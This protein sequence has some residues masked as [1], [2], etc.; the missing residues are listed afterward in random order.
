M[1]RIGRSPI[2]VPAG[3]EVKVDENNHV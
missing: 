1:S 3:V 2:T